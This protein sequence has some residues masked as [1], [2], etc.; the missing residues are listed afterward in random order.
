MSN[1]P[2]KSVVIVGNGA[3]LLNRAN[4]DFIDSHDIVVRFNLFRID[5]F[6]TDVGTKTT[7]WFNNRDAESV[8]IT[9]LLQKH[10][11]ECI[12]VHTWT[13]TDKAVRSF[14]ERLRQM[15]SNTTVMEVSKQTI[16]DMT[17]YLADSYTMFSTGAIGVWQMLQSHGFVTLIGFDW[18][19]G[20]EQF[21]YCDNARF[22]YSQNT[23]H[24]PR[25]ER[26]FFEKLEQQ[27]RLRFHQ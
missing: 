15:N 3:S 20:H 22:V 25:L 27:G 13:D 10:A 14:H 11:F 2:A 8:Q 1:V 19:N 7:I 23:G 26:R 18:W 21:H 4:G 17:R 6:A 24:Q 9:N 16:S 12:Y 5:G